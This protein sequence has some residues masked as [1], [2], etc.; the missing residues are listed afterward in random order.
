MRFFA[1]FTFICNSCFLISMF[2][3]IRRQF[4]YSVKTVVDPNAPVELNYFVSS[5]AVLAFLAIIVNLI[6]VVIFI[7][8]YPARR[9]NNI[10]RWIVYSNMIILPMQVYFILFT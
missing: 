7:A 3:W 4:A 5:A 9:M 10:P 2:L 8:R 6:F 1:R